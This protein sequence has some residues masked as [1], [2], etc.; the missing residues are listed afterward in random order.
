MSELMK[1][2]W[3]REA[4]NLNRENKEL[5][6]K[7]ADQKQKIIKDGY[8]KEGTTTYKLE[9]LEYPHDERCEGS[10]CY[11]KLRAKKESKKEFEEL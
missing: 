7:L 4:L 9:V 2:F 6:K 11:C 10:M 1:N 8:F 3:K 5:K